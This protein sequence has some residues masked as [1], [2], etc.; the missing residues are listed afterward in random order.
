MYKSILLRLIF[1]LDQ[2]GLNPIRTF[3]ALRNLPWF[4]SDFLFFFSRSVHTIYLKPCLHDRFAD[5]GI[6]KDEY[7]WQD[8]L[9]A[10][11]VASSKPS[12]HVDIGSRID[13]FVAHLASFRHIEVL[14]IRPLS[15]VIPGVCFRQLDITSDTQ[16]EQFSGI[17]GYAD[18]LSCL[19]VLEHFGLGRYGD[20]LDINGHVSGLRNLSKL[21]RPGGTLYLS[22]PIGKARIE[23]NSHRVFEFHSLVSLAYS[24]DLN[25]ISFCLYDYLNGLSPIHQYIPNLFDHLSPVQYTLAIMKYNKSP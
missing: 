21:L 2:F 17:A 23:F 18:S 9:V 13:G 20:P 6:T 5:S 22:V 24:F 3:R 11:W 7:F 1:T 19:H 16:V 4:L 8:L 25:L 14:D 10:Q 12:R 15:N